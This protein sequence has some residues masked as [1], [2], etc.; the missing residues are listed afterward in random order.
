MRSAARKL[1]IEHLLGKKPKGSRTLSDA[2]VGKSQERDTKDA[3]K[4]LHA[5]VAQTHKSIEQCTATLPV[6][7]R[8]GWYVAALDALHGKFEE[9]KPRK[10]P[11]ADVLPFKPKEP[12]EREP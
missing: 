3:R 8:I 11:S 12:K 4:G 7:D 9:F 2:S 10:G 6:V 5:W 1:H